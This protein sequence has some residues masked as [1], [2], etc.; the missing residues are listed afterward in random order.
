MPSDEQLGQYLDVLS[1]YM[2]SMLV[3]YVYGMICLPI[4]LT[5]VSCTESSLALVLS[6]MVNHLS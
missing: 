5:Q 2:D 1:N 6:V 3:A 4:A